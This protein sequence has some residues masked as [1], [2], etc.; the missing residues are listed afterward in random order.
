[1]SVNRFSEKRVRFGLVKT[2]GLSLVFF[3]ALAVFLW[4]GIGVMTESTEA[5][6]LETARRAVVQAAVHCY[7]LEGEYPPDIDYL[8]EHYGLRVEESFVYHYE[9]FAS[10]IMPDITVLPREGPLTEAGE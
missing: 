6:K 1:V 10:N 4:Q 7:A 5:E 8:R 3:G 9:G 2:W